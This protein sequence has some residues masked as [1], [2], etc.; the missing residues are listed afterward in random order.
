MAVVIAES[1]EVTKEHNTIIADLTH[2]SIGA[3]ILHTRG[4][5]AHMTKLIIDMLT[6]SQH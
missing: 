5:T 6:D 1:V 4:Q 2:P 3:S